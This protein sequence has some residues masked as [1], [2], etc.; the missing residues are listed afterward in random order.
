M[1]HQL[2]YTLDDLDALPIGTVVRAHRR[3]SA[4]KGTVDVITRQPDGWYGAWGWEMPIDN[5][6]IVPCT[7]LHRGTP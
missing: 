5:E 3:L 7:V 6:D 4:Y 2:V 1:T